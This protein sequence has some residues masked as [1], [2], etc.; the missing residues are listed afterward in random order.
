MLP[1]DRN[2]KSGA[3]GFSIVVN[4]ERQLQLTQTLGRQWDANDAAGMTHE[5]G[6]LLRRG[7]FGR[8]NE[9]ALVFA[10]GMVGHDHRLA[11]R[12]GLHGRFNP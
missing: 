8:H 10:T 7:F 3:L 12:D 4:H 2:R 11:A 1:V 5:K 9:I 6:N